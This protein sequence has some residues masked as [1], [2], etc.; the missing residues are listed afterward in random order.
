MQ[1]VVQVSDS[2][3]ICAELITPGE[4]GAE[5]V[6]V[7]M[8]FGDMDIILPLT[9]LF[10]L[11]ESAK[12]VHDEVNSKINESQKRR[13]DDHILMADAEEVGGIV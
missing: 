9:R 10:D 4:T 5:F 8:T 13:H 3:K 1:T 12:S 11:Y 2:D 7:K 6:E